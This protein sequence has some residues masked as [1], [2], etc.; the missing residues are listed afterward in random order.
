MTVRLPAAHR[1]IPRSILALAFVA[2]G[3][4]GHAHAG[5]ICD[6]APSPPGASGTASTAEGDEA[7][8][9][10]NGNVAASAFS[11]AIGVY[12]QVGTGADHALA[13]GTGN[14]AADAARI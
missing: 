5:D 12:S 3:I 4:A 11:T 6:T 2:A 9:C 1:R 7:F 8:A 13:L 10:G 14:S